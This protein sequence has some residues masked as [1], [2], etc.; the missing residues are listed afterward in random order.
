MC[1]IL[2][3]CCCYYFIIFCY[4]NKR[5]IIVL[6]E[7]IGLAVRDLVYTEKDM[8]GSVSEGGVI[9]AFWKS[10]FKSL[11]TPYAKSQIFGFSSVR[12]LLFHT[13]LFELLSYRPQ[14]MLTSW[15]KSSSNSSSKFC[16][17]EI[18]LLGRF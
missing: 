10:E 6:I 9:L 18:I 12:W 8:R 7:S 16:C 2:E 17:Y 5:V 1:L 11:T 13:S 15:H 4:R 14:W 3:L